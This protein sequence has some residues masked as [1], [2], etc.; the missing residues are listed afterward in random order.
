M[1][2]DAQT[3]FLVAAARLRADEHGHARVTDRDRASAQDLLDRLG[4]AGVGLVDLTPVVG[5]SECGRQLPADEARAGYLVCEHC[6]A[7]RRPLHAV[8]DPT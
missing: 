5:C 2:G 4:H 8:P 1:S 3:R 7:G 6:A